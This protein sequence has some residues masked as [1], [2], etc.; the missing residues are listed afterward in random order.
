MDFVY[1]FLLFC[2]LTEEYE[3]CCPY[4]PPAYLFLGHSIAYISTA[5]KLPEGEVAPQCHSDLARRY[6]VGQDSSILV[7]LTFWAR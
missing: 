3:N 1:L 2:E 7:L 4:L 6:M 5:Q